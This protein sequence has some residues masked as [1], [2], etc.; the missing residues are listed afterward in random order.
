[1]VRNDWPVKRDYDFN[2]TIFIV[3]KIK[4]LEMIDL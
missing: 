1:M 3:P 4:M 2:I